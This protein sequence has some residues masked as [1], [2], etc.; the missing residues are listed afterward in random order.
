V[1]HL[2]YRAS[3][4]VT[5][6]HQ[7]K[8]TKENKS[9]RREKP[10]QTKAEQTPQR[11]RKKEKNINQRKQHQRTK[12]S[13]ASCKVA[14]P[15]SER[16]QHES[17]QRQTKA[18]KG[19]KRE[20]TGNRKRTKPSRSGQRRE[21]RYSGCDPKV[22]LTCASSCVWQL[23]WLRLGRKMVNVRTRVE[24]YLNCTF[25]S[26]TGLA[27]HNWKTYSEM[28]Q[29]AQ[30]KYNIQVSRVYRVYRVQGLQVIWGFAWVRAAEA[31]RV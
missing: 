7:R 25:H 17:E 2:G 3:S 6:K 19:N 1:N 11:K 5:S 10:T 8:P 31:F 29:L 23:K 16:R 30:E 26:H 24:D 13:A 27:L 4:Q 12:H 9:D 14:A 28:R 15:E 21:T 22:A 18:K 20:Q